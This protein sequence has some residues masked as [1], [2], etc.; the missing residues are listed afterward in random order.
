MPG[1]DKD[2]QYAISQSMSEWCYDDKGLLKSHFKNWKCD[3]LITT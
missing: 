2:F 3:G 1:W